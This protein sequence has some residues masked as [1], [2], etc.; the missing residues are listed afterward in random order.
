[1]S[2]SL[3]LVLLLS[4]I[5]SS[6]IRVMSQGAEQGTRT[7]AAQKSRASRVRRKEGEEMGMDD[8]REKET[9]AITLTASSSS[10]SS[11][12]GPL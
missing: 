1:M 9:A 4:W 7:P 2:V 6:H 11:A 5:H 12:A 3:V 8:A 10:S